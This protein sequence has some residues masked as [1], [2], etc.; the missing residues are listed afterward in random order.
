MESVIKS[1][2]DDNWVDVKKYVEE[3]TSKI[4][5]SKIDDKKVEVLANINKVTTEEMQEILNL[6]DK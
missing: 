5:K 6:N 3:E 1:V 4:I 2:L